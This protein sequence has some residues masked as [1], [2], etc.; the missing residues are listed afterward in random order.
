MATALS[1][2]FDRSSAKTL[3]DAPIAPETVERLREP[4]VRGEGARIHGDRG[5][6]LS[7]SIVDAIV[8]ATRESS[9]SPPGSA[10]AWTSPSAYPPQP[11]DPP[12]GLRVLAAL[13]IRRI[14]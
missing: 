10:A 4:F 14:G 8:T 7:L 9:S 11:T 2:P 1:F 5:T 6:G 3:L 13:R 12:S